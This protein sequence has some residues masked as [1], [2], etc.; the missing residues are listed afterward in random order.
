LKK[1]KSEYQIKILSATID[2]KESERKEIA[3]TLCDNV[4][5]LLFSANLH[6]M[7]VKARFKEDNI[8]LEIDKA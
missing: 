1:L 6:L 4:S 2:V 7:A 8:P 3:E 5:A